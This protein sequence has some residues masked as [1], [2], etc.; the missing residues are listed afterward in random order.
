MSNEARREHSGVVEY[1]QIAAAK[2]LSEFRELRVRDAT[3]LPPKHEQSRAAPLGRRILRDQR[4]WKIEIELGDMH[5]RTVSQPQAWP[6]SCSRCGVT[7]A[8]R[9]PSIRR[10][11][12]GAFR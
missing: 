1:E 7:T 8:L 4:L 2:I 12:L 11:T 9:T 6:S 3:V 10:N 5:V